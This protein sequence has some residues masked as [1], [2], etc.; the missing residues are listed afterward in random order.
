ML[1]SP[2]WSCRRLQGHGG[3][4]CSAPMEAMEGGGLPSSSPCFPAGK[5]S[6]LAD[7]MVNY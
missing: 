4:P 7:T 6:C 2:F 5:R 3:L 1:P